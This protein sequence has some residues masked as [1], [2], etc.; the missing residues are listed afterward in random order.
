MA[1]GKMDT[2]K[3]EKLIAASGIKWKKIVKNIWGIDDPNDDL[4]GISIAVEPSER[5]GERLL[6]FIV[7]IADVP[8]D[9]GPDFYKEF[10]KLNFK[11]EHGAFAMETKTEMVFIDTLELENLDDNE[12][13][14]TLRAAMEAPRTFQ[15]R[16]DIEFFTMGKPQF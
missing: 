11:V 1:G 14:A 2:E 12:F 5:N 13:S 9:T 16:Y 15:K 8:K 10:L 6:K 4:P 7:F 3:I